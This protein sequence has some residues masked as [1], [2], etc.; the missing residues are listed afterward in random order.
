VEV[1]AVTA[2][3]EA[4]NVGFLHAVSSLAPPPGQLL[5]AAPP[6]QPAALAPPPFPAAPPRDELPLRLLLRR[7]MTVTVHKKKLVQKSVIT[8]KSAF[9]YYSPAFICIL[10]LGLMMNNRL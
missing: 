5:A 4:V 6:L 1:C 2:A 9:T 10:K 3:G 8:I 7:P